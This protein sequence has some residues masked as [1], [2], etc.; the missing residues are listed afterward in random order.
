M[1]D[2]THYNGKKIV[3]RECR[4]AV[5]VPPPSFSDPD[6]HVVKEVLHLEDNTKVPNLRHIWNYQRPFWFVK[7][8]QQ[9]FKQYMDYIEEDRCSKFFSN[10]T[11]LAAKI[12]KMSGKGKFGV[13]LRDAC[14]TP[15]VFGADIKSTSCI[16]KDYKLAYPDLNTE[17][18]VAVFDI[19]TDMVHGTEESIMATISYKENCL[20]VVKKSFV[21]GILDI[22]NKLRVLLKKYLGDIIEKRNVNVEFMF[23]DTAIETFAKCFER[24]H[25]LQPDFVS[26]WNQKFDIGKFIT[27]CEMAGVDPAQI[28]SDPSVPDEY[29]FFRF[30]IGP[31][32]KKT[33]KG[34]IMPMAPS[35]QWHTAFFPASFYIMDSMCAYRQTRNGKQQETSYAL[36]NILKRNDLGGKLKFAEAD[37]YTG[38]AWH[39]FMQ[40][41]YPLEYIIY[42]IYDC[43]GVEMLDE[44]VKDLAVVIQQF[45]DTSDFE[46]FKSQ[47]RRKCDE[48][49]WF[50]QENGF[51]IGCTNNNLSG[52]LDKEILGRNDWIITL[53]NS[54]IERS[55]LRII[56]ENPEIATSCFAHIGDQH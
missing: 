4:F 9:T 40:R 23:V 15:Y 1:F 41:N 33:A 17:F 11:Q 22:E 25:K 31:N 37:E 12:S 13:G 26:I 3:A 6:L 47:P 38:A 52:P 8:G 54:M 18:S 45:A 36:D 14:E 39:E 29:K 43:I 20:V 16:K 35:Q 24:A 49:H 55:G 53:A 56:L 32:Q 51:V 34:L 2:D 30:K 46:D 42:N 27:A 10:Q 19:E 21:D 44:K 7:K 5:Y 50:F 28:M 48:L